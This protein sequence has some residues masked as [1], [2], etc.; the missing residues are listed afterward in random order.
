M[1]KYNKLT[2][3]IIN[4]HSS[5][6]QHFE[7]MRI[8]QQALEQKTKIACNNLE[9]KSCP[10]TNSI[11][12]LPIF[13]LHISST[14]DAA[15]QILTNNIIDIIVI[16][17]DASVD[18][19]YLVKIHA[20]YLKLRNIELIICASSFDATL[21]NFYNDN[22]IYDN[23]IFCQKPINYLV[24]RQIIYNL[25]RK[26]AILKEYSDYNSVIE[27]YVQER[28]ETLIYETKHDPLT[29]SYNRS[30]LLEKLEY[31]TNIDN[32][33][34][35][36]FAVMFF[37]LDKFKSINDTYGHAIGD[38][39]LKNLTKRIKNNIRQHDMLF[40]IGGDE[41]VILALNI[42]NEQSIIPIATNLLNITKNPIEA[43]DIIIPLKIS[44]G[45]S[46]YPK[47]KQELLHKADLAMYKAKALGG[48]QFMVF[49]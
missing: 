37:D 17:L 3:L 25:S 42:T 29:K 11:L 33:D 36:M 5:I 6:I 41:F 12:H 38:E 10:N 18:I 8:E 46:I 45:I 19:D 14:I 23:L 31:L 34:L 49:E 47:H 7:T 21:I 30:E 43:N 40:R 9:K 13:S 16:D 26:C 4:D 28:T 1:L 44:I 32:K 35:K 39:V 24:L 27:H 20:I 15:E 2:L 48:N 22:Y